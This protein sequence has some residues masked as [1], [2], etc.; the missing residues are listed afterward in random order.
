MLGSFSGH[1]LRSIQGWYCLFHPYILQLSWRLEAIVTAE[2]LPNTALGDHR[3]A[4][5][6][7][8]RKEALPKEAYQ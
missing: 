8:K 5:F 1:S 6:A 4:C 7:H 2:Q 3:F